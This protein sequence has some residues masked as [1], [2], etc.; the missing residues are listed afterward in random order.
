MRHLHLNAGGAFRQR[1]N[2]QELRRPTLKG[3]AN[4]RLRTIGFGK[5]PKFNTEPL[6]GL[7]TGWGKIQ[8]YD[9]SRVH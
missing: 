5:H 3:L 2:E 6:V 8:P 7:I 9:I 4:K 1:N